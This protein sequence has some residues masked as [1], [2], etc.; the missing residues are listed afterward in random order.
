MI[1]PFE[2]WLS[3]YNIPDGSKILFEESIRC[4]KMSAYRSAYIMSYIAFQSVLKHRMLHSPVNKPTGIDQNWWT[5]ILK[6]LGNDD[7]WDATVTDCVKRNN[8]DRVFLISDSIVAE[9]E[10]HRVT[11]N[12][13]AH[14]K[15]GKIEYYHVEC[16]W[17]FIQENFYRF[18]LN[19]GKAGIIQD[20]RNHYDK[21][22][23]APGTDSTYIVDRIKLGVLDVDLDDLIRDFYQIC[24]DDSV[25]GCLFS[26][27]NR[28]ID[29]WDK[30]VNESD[31]RI[32]DAVVRFIKNEHETSVCDFVGRYP[33]IADIFLADT[34]LA[35]KLWTG[36]LKNCR[37]DE[38]GFWILL[39]K[40]I[41]NNMVPDGE[42]EDFDKMVF[43][44]VGKSFPDEHRA[45]LEQTTYFDRLKNALFL[46]TNYLPPNG[47]YYA[48]SIAIPFCHYIRIFG[49]DEHS[50]ACINLIFS[51]AS[52]GDFYDR[53]RQM[54]NDAEILSQYQTIVNDKS[55]DD[56][57]VKFA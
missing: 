17:N 41:T 21:T 20:I 6:K 30:L 45:L 32:Q 24:A 25:W 2:K 49:L 11:R 22:I 51:F 50:V 48:N 56:Y 52:F 9:Y 35:R 39:D 31:N 23:T 36:L 14:G 33:A 8:P 1:I 5:N 53:V 43:D 3:E 42:K 29:L 46:E 13:C 18:V 55:W 26:D 16:F 19:G 4:Y 12:K 54:M 27:N 40:I 10:A 34:A 15:A 7:T 47:I 37:Y 38:K 57:S 44:S 28:M